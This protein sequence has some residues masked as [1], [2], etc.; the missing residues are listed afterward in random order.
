MTLGEQRRKALELLAPPP[1]PARHSGV[2]RSLSYSRPRQ[3]GTTTP[4]AAS[5]ASRGSASSKPSII[6]VLAERHARHLTERAQTLQDA[7]KPMHTDPSTIWVICYQRTTQE[8]RPSDECRPLLSSRSAGRSG[9][10]RILL[11]LTSEDVRVSPR[12][13]YDWICCGHLLGWSLCGLQAS[14]I[15]GP[16]R[17]LDRMKAQMLVDRLG[18]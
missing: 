15:V 17:S 1:K 6:G 10:R 12:D 2:V 11:L 14:R 13:A 4:M 5:R 16:W 8:R 7:R 9:V 3:A 18:V